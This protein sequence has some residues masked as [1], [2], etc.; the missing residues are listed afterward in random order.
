V[1]EEGGR[2]P[3]AGGNSTKGEG[4]SGDVKDNHFNKKRFPPEEKRRILSPPQT[5]ARKA[6][7]DTGKAKLRRIR[8]EEGAFSK[9]RGKD[10]YK[11]SSE[12]TYEPCQRGVDGRGIR[13]FNRSRKI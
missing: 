6:C 10:F 3:W 12:W 5:A 11:K 4:T 8:R 2:V 9:R 7:F 13:P 1:K